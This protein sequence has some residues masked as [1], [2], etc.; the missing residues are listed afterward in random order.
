MDPNRDR[1]VKVDVTCPDGTTVSGTDHDAQ[2]AII[3]SR[4]VR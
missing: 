3:L 1:P 4:L 2:S